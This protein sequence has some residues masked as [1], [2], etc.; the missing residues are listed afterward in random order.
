MAERAL[1]RQP[2]LVAGPDQPLI[3]VLLEEGGQQ[4]VRYF[5][6]EE[7]A[8]AALRR[9]GAPKARQLAGAWKHLMDWEEAE[10][11][12]DRIRHQTPP[13]PPIEL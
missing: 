3:G 8:D 4:V 9:R 10:R 12:L 2:G 13:T 5:A 1:D 6:D 7:E 11:D